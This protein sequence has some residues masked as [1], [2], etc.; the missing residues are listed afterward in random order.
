MS[1]PSL[2]L[3]RVGGKR[4]IGELFSAT[5][6]KIA[7]NSAAVGFSKEEAISDKESFFRTYKLVRAAF[8]TRAMDFHAQLQSKSGP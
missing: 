3:I 8:R 1:D 7:A 4:G 6:A 2:F 5:V